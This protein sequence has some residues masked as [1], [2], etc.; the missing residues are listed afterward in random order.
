MQLTIHSS[1]EQP[2]LTPMLGQFKNRYVTSNFI[3]KQKSFLRQLRLEKSLRIITRKNAGL[4][5]EQIRIG[6]S[7]RL[8]P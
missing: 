1:L 8:P 2:I 5:N 4:P 6:E 7:E 3:R